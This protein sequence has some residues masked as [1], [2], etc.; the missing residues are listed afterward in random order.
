MHCYGMWCFL[1]RQIWHSHS[2]LLYRDTVELKCLFSLNLLHRLLL[3]AQIIL[4]EMIFFDQLFFFFLIFC[5]LCFCLS[6]HSLSQW[7]QTDTKTKLFIWCHC[8][9]SVWFFLTIFFSVHIK[10]KLIFLFYELAVSFL[11]HS[12]LYVLFLLVRGYVKVN[13][14]YL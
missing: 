3:N 8:A 2:W 13:K 6:S 12:L 1:W 9:Y 10:W 5:V 11:K 7:Q 14:F 4:N